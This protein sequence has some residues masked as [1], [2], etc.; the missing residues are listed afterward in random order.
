MSSRLGYTKSVTGGCSI[1][2]SLSVNIYSVRFLMQMEVTD[3]KCFILLDPSRS[4]CQSLPDA[5]GTTNE[6]NQDLCSKKHPTSC[7]Q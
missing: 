3:V 1:F 5:G 6:K 4:I 2:P 7:L